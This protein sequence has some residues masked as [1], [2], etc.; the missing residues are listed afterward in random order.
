MN[1]ANSSGGCFSADQNCAFKRVEKCILVEGNNIF[2][3]KFKIAISLKH[4]CDHLRIEKHPREPL[5]VFLGAFPD[6]ILGNISH[7]LLRS[8][9]STKTLLR[10]CENAK[11][12]FDER[13]K[14]LWRVHL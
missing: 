3:Y 11:A 9:P 10:S 6:R 5:A 1:A 2:F 4:N 14:K 13:S 8:A 7:T 12:F